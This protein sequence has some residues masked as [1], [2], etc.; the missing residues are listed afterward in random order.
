MLNIDT[1]KDDLKINTLINAMQENMLSNVLLIPC[2]NE[3]QIVDNV[4]L[5][6]NID[7]LLKNSRII[8]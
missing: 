4:I 8:H 1:T 2:G 6:L 5:V 7:S 3:F